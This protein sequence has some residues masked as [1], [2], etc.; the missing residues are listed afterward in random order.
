MHELGQATDSAVLREILANPG[1]T[2]SSIAEA[3]GWSNGKVDGSINRLLRRKEVVVK[4]FLQRGALLKKVYPKEYLEKPRNMVEVPQEMIG[5]D[6]WKKNAFVYALSRSTIGVTPKENEEWS[7]RALI[8]EV[9]SLRKEPDGV[10]INLPDRLSNFYELENSETSLSTVGEMAMVTVESILPV[11]LP[12]TYPEDLKL[13][14]ITYKL[15]ME[16]ELIGSASPDEFFVYTK[17]GISAEISFSTCSRYV[18]LKKSDERIFTSTNAG[19]QPFKEIL[20][21]P[22]VSK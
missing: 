21:L 6:L 5:K 3:M 11:R 4:H 1:I 16:Q 2:V 19:T 10:V 9:A 18:N 7:N 22:V 14:M 15:K 8:S 17:E 20:T 12:S 13:P